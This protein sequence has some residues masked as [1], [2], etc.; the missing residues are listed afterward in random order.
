MIPDHRPRIRLLSVTESVAL[1]PDP[2]DWRHMPNSHRCPMRELR[3]M[4]VGVQPS[5]AGPNLRTLE[6]PNCEL[7]YKALAEGPEHAGASRASS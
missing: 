4:L 6:C 5:F 3:M 1:P 2:Q 7:A